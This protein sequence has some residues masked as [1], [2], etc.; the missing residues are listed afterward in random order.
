M[1]F[2]NF[3]ENNERV[4]NNADSFAMAFDK[5]WKSLQFQE[6]ADIPEKVKKISM[7]MELV[8][9]HPFLKNSPSEARKVAEFRVRLLNLG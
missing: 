5:A 8:K 9:D 4:F 1:S 2:P 7:A 3:P 6:N